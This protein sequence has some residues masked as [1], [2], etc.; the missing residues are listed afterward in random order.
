MSV[1]EP[2]YQIHSVESTPKIHRSRIYWPTQED[3]G[4]RLLIQC[5][6]CNASGRYGNPAYIYSSIVLEEPKLSAI[7]RR[8]RITPSYIESHDEIRVVSYNILADQY[9]NSD[10]AFQVLYPYCKQEALHMDYRQSLIV[11]ELLGYH[12]DI[13]CL[14]EVA[15]KCFETYLLPVMQEKGYDGHHAVKT[16]QVMTIV[17]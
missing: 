12:P 2:T 11:K 4:K 14:Q 16:G 13:V 6:P 7:N 1:L 5:T 3:V 10:F 15:T 9:S 8:Q 17:Y